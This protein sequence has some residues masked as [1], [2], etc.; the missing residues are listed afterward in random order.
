[1][2]DPEELGGELEIATRK[3]LLDLDP[4]TD[5][6]EERVDWGFR[7]EP[8]LPAVVLEIVSDP[9]PA[10]FKGDQG[11]RV[12]RVQVDVW[13]ATRMAAKRIAQ[14]V[15]NELKPPAVVL[16]PEGSPGWVAGMA[17]GVRFERAF[18]DGPELTRETGA[19]PNTIVHRARF[20]LLIWWA[21]TEGA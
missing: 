2:A 8:P 20:D 1:V 18:C 21:L 7:P 12:T 15:I 4:L 13:A 6:V 19:T 5:Q 10:H 11:L 14:L 16:I 17:G 9:R 3:R